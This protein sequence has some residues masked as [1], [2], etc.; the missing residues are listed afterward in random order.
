MV[1]GSHAGESLCSYPWLE[2][3]KAFQF[4]VRCGSLGESVAHLSSTVGLKGQRESIILELYCRK[5]GRK[6]KGRQ[7]ESG[8][9][10]PCG[11]KG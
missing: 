8:W 11:E 5:A 3:R 6:R 4:E 1:G 10:W 2:D 9:P 7:K